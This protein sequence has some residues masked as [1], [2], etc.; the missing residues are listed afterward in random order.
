VDALIA[1]R[2]PLFWR[3]MAVVGLVVALLLYRYLWLLGRG[4]SRRPGV[5]AGVRGV[6]AATFQRPPAGWSSWFG[7]LWSDGILHRRL[8]QTDRWRWAAHEAML[9]GFLG[10]ALLSFLAALS[11]HVFRP[12]GLDPSFIAALRDK[13]QPLLA[14]LHETLGL[15]L[16]LGGLAAAI[17]RFSRR[18]AHLPREGSDAAVIILLL[19]ITV[20]GYPLESLRLL[21]E[22]VPPEVARYSYLAWPLAQ[23]I[24]PLELDWAAWHFWTF[25]AHVVFSVALFLYWPF[26]K[27]MHVVMGPLVAAQEAGKVEPSR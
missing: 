20:S 14:A 27:M 26:G 18:D 17:R 15:L 4:Y 3:M 5:P 2:L 25:Q 8:R 21:M 16:L 24:R 7:H 12:L 6:L 9:L 23:W 22:Q 1:N 13:D 19:V 10:L 11:D